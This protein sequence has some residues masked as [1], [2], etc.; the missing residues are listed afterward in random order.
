KL[1][2]K[3]GYIQSE[4]MKRVVLKYTP[5]LEFRSDDSVERGVRVMSILDDIGDLDGE[6]SH[7]NND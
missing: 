2:S 5:S 1:N 3:H 7:P 4:V 6:E